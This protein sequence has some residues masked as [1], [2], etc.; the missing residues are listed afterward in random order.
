MLGLLLSAIAISSGAYMIEVK[1]F[2]DDNGTVWVIFA[3]FLAGMEA[4]FFGFVSNISF[5]IANKSSF[6]IWHISRQIIIGTVVIVVLIGL[7][8]LFKIGSPLLIG[9]DRVTFWN[10]FVPY[11]FSFYPSLVMQTYFFVCYYV[12]AVHKR[13][14]RPLLSIIVL[15]L[16]IFITIAVL[17]QKFSAF[18]LLA[19]AWLMILPGAFP[20]FQIR[21]SYIIFAV[22]VLILIILLVI[23]TYI[24]SG[25]EAS[26]ILSRIS[27]QSQL[28]WSVISDSYNFSLFP[29][30]DWRCY[31]SCGFTN[32]GQDYI[33]MQYL[34]HEIYSY[35]YKN[36]TTLS[37]F[38]PSLSILT[39]GIIISF[40]IHL[41]ICFVM[42]L[43]QRDICSAVRENNFILSFLLYKVQI[44]LMLVWFSAI[45]SA[46]GG[47]II[48]LVVLGIYLAAFGKNR[49]SLE[50]IDMMK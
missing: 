12:I 23:W 44:G 34:P 16:Y 33:V 1:A 10:S 24:H 13:M 5:G 28:I 6:H 22:I 19:S 29:R 35:Y 36:G 37:G 46:I 32:N 43:I 39:F 15:L 18:I 41:L 27:L 42:G 49:V 3:Y 48:T 14:E 8:I 31:F 9:V 38:M 26:F 11:Y 17:G 30:A 47:V 2:G 50:H 7:F 25:M 45:N 21:I 4:T 20:N 40:L